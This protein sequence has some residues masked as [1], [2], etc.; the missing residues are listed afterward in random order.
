MNERTI[1]DRLNELHAALL[2][3]LIEHDAATPEDVVLYEVSKGRGTWEGL[4]SALRYS[5]LKNRQDVGDVLADTLNKLHA[6]G[7]VA[8][9]SA[10]GRR[11][12]KPAA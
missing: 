4:L 9:D 12:Y 3:N 7:S 5:V 1:D 8:L 2:S 6:K 11:Q 10:E